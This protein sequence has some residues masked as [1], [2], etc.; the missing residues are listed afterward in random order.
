MKVSCLQENLSRG[1]STVNRA[2]PGKRSTLPILNNVL[3]TTDQGQLKLTASN[4]EMTI[5]AW[6]GGQVEEEGAITV[7]TR[8]LAEIV[9]SLPR[10]RVDIISEPKG[11]VLSC[12]KF[13]T[14]ISS[15]DAED[16]P[17]IPVVQPGVVG[18]VDA[19]VLNDAISHVG[20]AA[21]TEDYRPIL[22]GI[23]VELAGGNFTFVAAD[24][25]RLAVYKGLLKEAVSEDIG[26][27]VPAK[28]LREVSRLL[29]R[30]EYPVEVTISTG[31]ILF[32]FS[33]TELVSWLIQGTFPNYAQLIPQSY[34]TRIVV[35][36]EQ[37]LK[38][39]K[40]ASILTKEGSG[41]I[42][43]QATGGSDG[44]PGRLS[45]SSRAE[46]LGDNQGEIDA[47]VEGSEAKIAFS[48]KYLTEAL[49]AI[50]KGEV[51]LETTT[52]S[53]P[54]VLRPLNNPASRD[55]VHVVMP[56]FVQW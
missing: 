11:I 25:F 15:D 1:L 44:S 39:I 43:I 47:K 34:S 18:S 49:K 53:S 37:F 35:D 48:S 6:V 19:Q 9:K 13:T 12:G 7:P 2:I 51:A 40:T 16:F 20:F 30:Q 32:R 5:S 50:G 8:M 52:P 27:I 54:G 21:A 4:L 45:V 31:R 28:T 3:L 17:P 36:R 23:K 26:F 14:R 41:I 22:T 33:H 10:E 46:E 55:Y 42:R 38:A 29:G 24:G 56:T